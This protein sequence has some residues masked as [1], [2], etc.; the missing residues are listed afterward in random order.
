MTVIVISVGKSI[1]TFVVDVIVLSDRYG[2]H[3]NLHVLTQSFP[4]RRSSDL[5]DL[6]QV[7]RRSHDGP[8]RLVGRIARRIGIGIV[9]VANLVMR[10]SIAIAHGW[11]ARKDSR[12]RP[13]AGPPESTS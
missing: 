7:A 8:P 6:Q 4:T 10:G 5:V 2:D 3:P 11:T 12:R 13:R 9:L 1:E